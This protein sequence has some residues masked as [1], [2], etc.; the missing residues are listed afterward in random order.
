MRY[1]KKFIFFSLYLLLTFSAINVKAANNETFRTIKADLNKDKK[2]ETIRIKRNSN[3]NLDGMYNVQITGNGK[4]VLNQYVDGISLNDIY[5][6]D[7]YTEVITWL[8]G[9][10]LKIYRYNGEKMSLYATANFISDTKAMPKLLKKNYCYWDGQTLNIK[11]NGK[12]LIFW[13]SQYDIYSDESY[14]GKIRVY[15]RVNQNSIRYATDRYA[16]ETGKNYCYPGR[17]WIAYKYPRSDVN[18]KNFIIRRGERL[19]ILKLK[20]TAQYI[21]AQVR[22]MRTNETGWVLFSTKAEVWY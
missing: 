3:Y 5:S 4:T 11:S 20:I 13:E 7:R 10:K 16:I 6:S 9:G 8:S 2:A 14:D 18:Q 1:I 22:R 19:K 15:Y 21:Y 17:P 12:G